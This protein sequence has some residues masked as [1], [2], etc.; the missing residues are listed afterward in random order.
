MGSASPAASD[1][2]YLA[3]AVNALGHALIEY[4]R[5]K[6]LQRA[7][8]IA[9]PGLQKLSDL[10]VTGDRLIAQQIA[11][12]RDDILTDANSTI[13]A[14]PSGL[15][16]VEVTALVA[17]PVM[18]ANLSIDRLDSFNRGIL[19]VPSAH[20]ELADSICSSGGALSDLKQLIAEASA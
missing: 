5:V 20:Q 6:G 1:A 4:E 18:D 16:R 14:N 13:N 7:M 10:L 11:T 19:L 2:G 8:A 9:Q 17:G 12:Y 3:A 15:S